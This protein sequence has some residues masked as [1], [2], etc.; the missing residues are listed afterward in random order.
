MEMLCNV[1]AAELIMPIGSLSEEFN[2]SLRIENILELRAKYDV[3]AEAILIRLAKLADFPCAAFCASKR[4]D[5]PEHSSNYEIDYVI[6]SRSWSLTLSSGA[7]MS[8]DSVVAQCAAIG[9]TARGVQSW[10]QDGPSVHVECVG[11]PGY[12]GVRVPRVAGI[13]RAARRMGKTESLDYV[14][15]DAL[16]PR[17]KGRRIVGHIVND[18]TPNWGG[19]GFA[20][21]VKRKWPRVQGTFRDW[22]S[23]NRRL[24]RLGEAIDIEAENDVSVFCMIA[25]KGYGK[26][27]APRVRYIALET[28]LERLAARAGCISTHAKDRDR[29]RRGI[30]A[31]GRRADRGQANLQRC[32]RHG[33]QSPAEK[34][35][36]V[37]PRRRPERWKLSSLRRGF[38]AASRRSVR[39]NSV[40]KVYARC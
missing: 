40:R 22:V 4:G 18:A 39:S 37:R 31:S 36:Q 38:T 15:G 20:A 19:G 23:S 16:S 30:L 21:A 32:S 27:S 5:H 28:C 17:G 6:P 1:G 12:P 35:V 33:L 8:V 26:S 14:I 24:F 34:R 13:V 7:I 29:S 9:F 2:E 11:L 10:N 25:Q 3:S